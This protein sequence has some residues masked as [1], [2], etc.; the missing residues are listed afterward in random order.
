MADTPAG[1]ADLSPHRGWLLAAA[2]LAALVSLGFLVALLGREG[3][4]VVVVLLVPVLL[5]AAPLLAP[6]P[7]RRVVAVAAVLLLTIGVV[8]SV[9]S[10]GLYYLPSLVLLIIGILRP[11]RREPVDDRAAR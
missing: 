4:G 2:L 8:L 11:S 10:I 9:A 1:P 6:R 5:L 3:R 7:A